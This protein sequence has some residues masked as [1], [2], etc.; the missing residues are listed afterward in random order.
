MNSG[1]EW[2]IASGGVS[3]KPRLACAIDAEFMRDFFAGSMRFCRIDAFCRIQ[4]F[5]RPGIERRA[6]FRYLAA[7]KGKADMPLT[8]LKIEFNP[9]PVLAPC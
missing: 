6:M 8:C 1:A 2:T 4:L 5:F 9:R 3:G 7:T